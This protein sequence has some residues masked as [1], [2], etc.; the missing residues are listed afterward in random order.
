MSLKKN[1]RKP[2]FLLDDLTDEISENLVDDCPNEI[3]T[4]DN[5]LFVNDNHPIEV[6]TSENI[7]TASCNVEHW[8]NDAELSQENSNNYLPSSSTNTEGPMSS[9]ETL[10]F[11]S[12]PSQRSE[13][14]VGGRYYNRKNE[15]GT[16]NIMTENVV[17]TLDNFKQNII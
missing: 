17:A 5:Q 6:L 2:M 1:L 11:S 4:S 16:I 13:F 12:P 14:E 15:R 3:L 8:S 7:G 10:S 9:G